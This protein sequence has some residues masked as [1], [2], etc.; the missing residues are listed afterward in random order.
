MEIEAT[1][2]S[3][4]KGTAALVGGGVEG[5]A[6]DFGIRPRTDRPHSMSLFGSDD[7]A[8]GFAARGLDVLVGIGIGAAIGVL[9]SALLAR[10]GKNGR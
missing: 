5:P 2:T 7:A 8:Q 10:S 6:E 3:E 9:G 1:A 4:V